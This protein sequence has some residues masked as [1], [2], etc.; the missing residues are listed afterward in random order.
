[1]K[2]LRKSIIVLGLAATAI[3]GISLSISKNNFSEVNAQ[4]HIEN[5]ELYDYKNYSGI[6]Y[7]FLGTGTLTDGLNGTLRTKL[8]ANILPKDWYSYS[9][10]GEK[11]LSTILQQADEDPSNHDNMVFLYTRDSVKKQAA[12]TWNRE[13]TWPKSLSG[14][15]W[16]EGKAGTDILHLRP[17][18]QTPNSTRGNN[19]FAEISGGQKRTHNGMDFGYTSGSNFM[20]LD[21]V[22]GDVARIIMYVWVAY[23]DYY[24]SMP[25]ITNVFESYDTLLKWHTQDKPDLMEAH[26]NDVAEDSYQKN[27]NPFVDHPEYAWKIFGDSASAS[28]KNACMA[29]Y[30]DSSTPTPTK[31][32]TDLTYTGTPTKKDYVVGESFNPSGL[33][34]TAKFSDNTSQPVTN[35]VT[36]STLVEGQTSVTGSYT[37]QGTTKQIVI[38]GITVSKPVEKTLS[39][40]TK[41]GTLTKKDY[42]VGESFNPS[43][44]TITANFSDGSSQTVTSSVVWPTLVEGQTSIKGSYTYKGITE[45]ITVSGITVTKPIEKT[46]SSL[47]K[48]GTL[49]KKDYVVGESFDPTGLTITASYSDDTSENVTQSVTWSSLNVGD[50]SVTGSYSYEGT[51]KTIT[52]SGLT[53]KEIEGKQV[54]IVVVKNPNKVVYNIGDVF[55]LDGIKVISIFDNGKSV[56]VTDEIKIGYPNLTT[57]G[58]KLVNVSYENF[59]TTFC[60]VVL[61]ATVTKINLTVHPHKEEYYKN[62]K[63]NSSG[64]VVKAYL[65]NG[66]IIDNV[67][68]QCSFTYDFNKSEWVTVSFCD[69]SQQF[70]ITIL[71]GSPSIQHKAADFAYSFN[72]LMSEIDV[73][74]VSMQ[75]WESMKYYFNQLDAAS[76]AFIKNLNTNDGEGVSAGVSNEEALTECVNKYDDTYL[77]HKDEG[78]EDFIGR[79]PKPRET[80][81]EKGNDDLLVLIAVIGGIVLLTIII[82][83]IAVPVSKKH[84]RA[85]A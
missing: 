78:F 68:D 69:Q 16:G 22:K 44:L 84:K 20:P 65:S 13:H 82:V 61:E 52:I 10:S 15:N 37:Y 71:Q 70:K 4:Q 66:T 53:V 28:V 38:S 17:T 32:L 35:D 26:R 75:K 57:A 58:T 54:G 31:T 43:G 62:E 11:T 23:K 83:S 46:L 77:E 40:L 67:I 85:R 14:G 39:S 34:V 2:K 36:W 19:K 56:E 76:K 41:T 51:T 12:G 9:G 47:S 63:F 45:E 7:D 6:Y 3:C 80:S 8:S 1:M 5:F 72:V 30:P 27:R 18:Y 48:T 21:A 81:K 59:K 33:T 64:A 60:V 25:N 74:N 55:E 42:V 50:T 73:A 29:A 49:T 24:S 79:N